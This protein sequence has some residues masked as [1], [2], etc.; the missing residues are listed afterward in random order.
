MKR[1]FAD[2]GFTLIELLVTISIIA[3]LI[4]I[5]LPAVQS[6]RE[7]ARRMTCGNNLKQ[8]GLAL[9]NYQ[10]SHGCFPPGRGTVNPSVFST[11][12]YFLPYVEQANLYQ[13]IDFGSA[14]TTYS[15]PGPIIFDGT[16]NF[17]A[18]CT[19]V[20]VY[21]CPS[22]PA[23]GRAPGGVFGGTNYMGNAGSGQLNLGSLTGADGVFFLGSRTDFRD[24]LDGSSNT[25][26]FAERALGPGSSANS[27]LNTA[28]DWMLEIPSS[29]DPTTTACNSAV[30]NWNGERGAKWIL[31]NY[32][33][34]LYNHTFPP[35]AGS[36][37]CMNIQQQKSQ[38]A[39]RSWHPGGVMTMFCDG[40]MRF[41]SNSIDRT[42][43]RALG[44]RASGEVISEL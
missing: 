15:I 21:V 35:N 16:R 28:R 13:Q 6:A 4:A 39:A 32:G 17:P 12:A 27:A 20:P 9:H 42:V 19:L 37:D 7:A 26:A 36:W 38:C 24:L 41:F 23:G 34:T 44:T 8:L 33:N 30:G 18:A 11:H 31:G 5:L 29:G 2:R 1:P 40:H 3:V 25:I 43:W 22:D 10:S 14:P